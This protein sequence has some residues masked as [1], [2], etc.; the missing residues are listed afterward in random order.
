MKVT[1]SRDHP[2]FVCT[3]CGSVECM[4]GSALNVGQGKAP[5]AVKRLKVDVQVRECAIHATDEVIRS[6]RR[7]R[8]TPNAASKLRLEVHRLALAR[9][10]ETDAK[11]GSRRDRGTIRRDIQ[12]SAA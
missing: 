6:G 10:Q 11:H 1:S 12:W 4:P 8:M 7:R 2:H 5:R 9:P 3:A